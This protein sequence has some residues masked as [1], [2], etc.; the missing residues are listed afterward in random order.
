MDR[1]SLFFAVV[2]SLMTGL[3]LMLLL[4][5]PIGYS[6]PAVKPA[7][8][9]NEKQQRYEQEEKNRTPTPPRIYIP[10]QKPTPKKTYIPEQQDATPRGSQTALV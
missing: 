8:S 7:G 2:L 1:R 9:Q 4:G 5:S 3:L 6:A 10:E